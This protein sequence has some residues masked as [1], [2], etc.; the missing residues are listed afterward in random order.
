MNLPLLPYLPVFLSPAEKGIAEDFSG[1]VEAAGDE[2]GFKPGDEVM[3]YH[4]SLSLPFFS[5]LWRGNVL[6]V[7]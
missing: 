4:C 2:T 3:I 7:S 6:S 5:F 1:I